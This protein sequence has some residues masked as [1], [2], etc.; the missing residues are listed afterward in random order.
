MTRILK[1][2][3]AIINSL[4]DFIVDTAHTMGLGLTDKQLHFWL[5]GIA[6]VAI[7]IVCDFAFRKLAK[8][9]ISAI[10]FIYTFTIL[11]VGVLAIEIEQKV[12]NSGSMEF[13]DVVAGLS[14]FL[15]LSAL[16]ILA[17]LLWKELKSGRR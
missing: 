17:R 12:T 9:S 13:D 2:L 6:G 3:I 4:H 16:Y 14:G 1:L 15:A 8:W 10:S 5:L 11:V 7:F